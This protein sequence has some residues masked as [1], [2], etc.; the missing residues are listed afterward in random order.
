MAA[1]GFSDLGRTVLICGLGLTGRSLLRFLSASGFAVRAWD[2]RRSVPGRDTLQAECPSATFTSGDT[3][4]AALLA[5]VDWLA[6]SPGLPLDHPLLVAAHDAGIPRLGDIAVF[7]RATDRPVVGVTGSNGKSTVVTALGEMARAAGLRWP[8]GGNLAPPALDILDPDA[9]GYL[10]ELSSFQLDLCEPDT[11][12]TVGAV[13]NI[14]PDHLDRH[15]T[16]RDYIHAKGRAVAAAG[17][18]VL[19]A[20][21][22]HVRDLPATGSRVYFGRAATAQYRVVNEGVDAGGQRIC[23]TAEL[24]LVGRHNHANAAAAL[25]ISD[26]LGWDRTRALAG[27]RA[28]P[29]LPHRC[30]WVATQRGVI[31]IN[32]SKGTNV[33]AV[34]AAVDGMNGPLVVLLGGQSKGGDF[35]P[36]RTVLAA[37]A[38]KVLV[39]GQDALRIREQLG[40]AVAVERV[41]TLADA[42]ARARALAQSGD[43]VLLSPGCASFDQFAGYEDRGAQ[44]RAL[45]EQGRDA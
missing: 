29:G 18:A 34:E 31:W 39:F 9:E 44:F 43:A 10:L 7:L 27:L 33:G 6:V 22:G 24:K 28:F 1:R 40:D 35:V 12:L 21:D 45:V 42:V 32:D 15:G 14:S 16:L 38:R 8:T 17:V 30:E 41:N 13:L 25:A 3:D 5:G 23:D 11:A 19:N 26:A 36:L 37:K 4:V 20:D 2:S